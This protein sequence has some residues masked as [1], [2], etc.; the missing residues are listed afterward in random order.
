LE[1]MHRQIQRVL[2]TSAFAGHEAVVDMLATSLADAV[3]NDEVATTEGAFVSFEGGLASQSGRS[4][5]CLARS[6]DSD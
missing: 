1:G 6:G 5:C 3:V 4:S 2:T